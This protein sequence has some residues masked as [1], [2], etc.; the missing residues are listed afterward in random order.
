MYTAIR[1]EH[2]SAVLKRRLIYQQPSRRVSRLRLDE[3]SLSAGHRSDAARTFRDLQHA[4]FLRLRKV[5][6][7][8][9]SYRMERCSSDGDESGEKGGLTLRRYLET[10]RTRATSTESRTLLLITGAM[11]YN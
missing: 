8:P 6:L 1:R 4:T 7:D 2:L 11:R 3:N 10:Q 5:Q 9:S